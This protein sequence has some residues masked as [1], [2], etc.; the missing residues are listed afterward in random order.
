MLLLYLLSHPH[1]LQL[2]D[3]SHLQVSFSRNIFEIYLYSGCIYKSHLR[4]RLS[5]LLAESLLLIRLVGAN[6]R[7]VLSVKFNKFPYFRYLSVQPA[8]NLVDE[9]TGATN[10]ST[11]VATDDESD[12]E[13]EEPQSMEY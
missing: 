12:E 4:N 9:L 11:G 5:G 6:G 2:R 13:E 1:Q 7:F 3:Y 10:E 8:K